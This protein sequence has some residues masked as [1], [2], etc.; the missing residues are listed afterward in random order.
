MRYSLKALIALAIS[1]ITIA[2]IFKI[3]NVQITVSDI[4]KLDFRYIAIAFLL[5]FSFWLLWALRLKIIT[6]TLGKRLRFLSSLEITLSSMF[7]AAITPS[8]AGGEPIRAKLIGDI[9]KSYGTASAVVLIERLLDAMFFAV[10]L[11]ILVIITDFS[12]G[13]GFKVAGIFSVSLIGF[14]FILYLLFKDPER[15]D[16]L[17]IYINYKILRKFLGRRVNAMTEK[18][19]K[20]AHNFRNALIEIINAKK[21]STTLI[22]LITIFMWIL[23]FLIP[24]F[25]LLAMDKDPVYLLSITAQLII[26]V[27]SLI[28]LTPGSSGIAEGSM[29]Y[30]YSN[31][32]P[33]NVLGVLVAIWRF[34]TYYLNLLFGFIVSLKI[35]KISSHSP[36][37]QH[38]N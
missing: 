20:E 7:F 30:L 16:K 5:Q 36:R 38:Q 9:C 3:T 29:A 35:L 34:I 14:L 26:V 10:A 25:I 19:L 11:P 15:L 28:P 17:I 22:I 23:G 27:V 1:V 13:F 33:S 4:K 24:S 21:S 32:V 31:F 6:E 18:T 12:I 8:S 2:M 37:L